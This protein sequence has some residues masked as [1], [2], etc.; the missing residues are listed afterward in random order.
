MVRVYF[1]RNDNNEIETIRIEDVDRKWID[2]DNCTLWFDL[3]NPTSDEADYVLKTFFSFHPLVVE[4][5]Q[6]LTEHPKIDDFQQYLFVLMHS[7]KVVAGV[8]GFSDSRLGAFLGENYLVTYHHET[9]ASIDKTVKFCLAN[10]RAFGKGPDN[11]F[12]LIIDDMVDEYIPVLDTIDALVD[13]IEDEIFQHP[14]SST[15]NKLITVKKEIM[16][17]RRVSTTQ[18]EILNRLS[19]GEFDLITQEERIFYRDVYDHLVRI[20]DLA[21]TYRDLV[22]GSLEAYLSVVS[23]KMNEVM[24]TL[25][26]ISTLMLPLTFIAGVYGM[27]FHLM[28][29]ISWTYGYPFALAIMLLTAL[30]MLWFFKRRKWF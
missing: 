2:S 14:K 15:L 17:L 4:D 13:G 8:E 20:S 9:I 24:K 26:I 23:N 30:G 12:H 16:R 6:N 29:E 11:I 22:T 1:L 28:P 5:C 3:C 25:T 18:K 27:N 10:P 19:R 7:V 21:E